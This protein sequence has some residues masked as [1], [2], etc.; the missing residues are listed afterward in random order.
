MRTILGALTPIAALAG[1][2]LTGCAEAAVRRALEGEIAGLHQQVDALQARACADPED[3][4]R[5][6]RQ[7]VQLFPPGEDVTVDTERGLARLRLPAALLQE[8]GGVSLRGQMALDLISGV[9][10]S[11]P[12]HAIRVTG[13][14]D[15]AANGMIPAWDLAR[16]AADVLAG[17]FGVARERMWIGVNPAPATPAVEI[18][19]LGPDRADP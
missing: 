15:A 2:P 19:F 1:L 18:V 14:G 7:L 11:N 10:A 13:R 17:R 16:R 5:L 6:V 9:L 3:G 12:R 8:A 4:A